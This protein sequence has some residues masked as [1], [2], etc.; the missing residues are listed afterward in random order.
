M[1]RTMGESFIRL[2]T[3]AWGKGSE[4]WENNPGPETTWPWSK[5][6]SIETADQTTAGPHP[7]KLCRPEALRCTE[8]QV[9]ISL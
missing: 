6:P 4:S 5:P 9:S 3:E 8:R 7:A 1:T 2:V